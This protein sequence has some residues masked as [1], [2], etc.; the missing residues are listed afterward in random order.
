MIVKDFST[1]VA[2]EMSQGYILDAIPLKSVY[3]HVKL[4]RVRHKVSRWPQIAIF[5][6]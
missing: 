2:K 3:E 6:R 5:L 1:R 4:G